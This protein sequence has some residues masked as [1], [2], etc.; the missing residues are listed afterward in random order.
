MLDC[1]RHLDLGCGL[2]PRNP[3][4]ANES[5]GCDI[6]E[7][8]SLDDLGFTYRKAN[9]IEEP[10]PYEDDFFDSVSAFDFIEHIPRQSFTTSKGHCNPFIDL[11]NEIYRVLR[12]GGVFLAITPAYPNVSAFTDPT[13]VNIITEHTHEY[14]CGT[15]PMGRVYGFTGKFEALTAKRETGSN[16]DPIDQPEFRKMMRRLHR[17]LFRGGLSHMLWELKKA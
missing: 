12:P 6:R 3:Y 5:F 16:V 14:F 7:I 11:M 4:G 8:D 2:S 13:H 10:I 9:L 17:R 1:K 15:E